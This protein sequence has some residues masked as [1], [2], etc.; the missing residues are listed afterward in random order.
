MKIIEQYLEERIKGDPYGK[1]NAPTFAFICF[2]G[3]KPSPPISGR[4]ASHPQKIYK[5]IGIDKDI[6]KKALD[7][8][9]NIKE[10]ELR[11][12]CQGDSERHLTFLIFRTLNRDP[13]YSEILSKK[14]NKHKDIK[15]CWDLGN[16]GLP[17]I[18]ITTNLWPEKDLKQF[19]SWWLS[20]SKRIKKSL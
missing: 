13:K 4:E 18:I 14:L 16:E 7:D 5:G 3:K 15:T 19:E 9:N 2:Y 8:L 17:R 11:S 20:L 1:I 6:P 12:S 10:I